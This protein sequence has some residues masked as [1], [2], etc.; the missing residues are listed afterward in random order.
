M[1]SIQELPKH[2]QTKHAE[3]C[4][5][6]SDDELIDYIKNTTELLKMI[7]YEKFPVTNGRLLLLLDDLKEEYFTRFNE[8]YQK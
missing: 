6:L 2:R 8:H 7:S 5:N 4:I 1:K 3:F